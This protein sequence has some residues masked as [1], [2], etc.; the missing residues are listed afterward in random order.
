MF[1]KDCRKY[2]IVCA[3]SRLAVV[4]KADAEHI[5]AAIS[6]AVTMVLVLEEEVRKKR[7]VL[8]MVLCNAWPEKWCG[9]SS[10][11]RSSTCSLHGSRA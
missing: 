8:L 9:S 1:C 11:R 4:A 7:L 3:V 6:T 5:T 2:V 10:Y